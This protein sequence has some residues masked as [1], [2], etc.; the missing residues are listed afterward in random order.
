MGYDPRIGFEFLHPGP[1]YGGSC[2]PKDVAALLHT[3]R[4][5]GLRLRACSRGVV[6]VNRR[7]HERMR[8]EGAR[9]RRRLA[10]RAS[11]V[12]VWGLTF[13]ANT[14]DLRDS[15]ALVIAARLLEE[16]AIV[17][18]YDPAAGEAAAA[19]VPGAR[20]A[21]ADPYEAATGAD[22]LA[23][24]TEWDEFRWLDFERVRR[25]RCARPRDRRRPEPARSGGD[26]PA[27]VRVPGRRPLMAAM[28]SSRAGR[29]RRLAPVRRA[30][31]ARVARSSRSTTSRPA[32]SRTSRTC[33]TTPAFD[34][35]RARRRRRASRSTGRS[36]RCCTSRARPARPSTSRT[37]LETLEVG[38]I[39][40]RRALDLARDQR[41]PVPARVDQ[42]GLRRPAGAPA[43]RDVLRQRQPDRPAV[44]LRRGEALRRGDHDGV[45]PRCTALDTRIVR[46]FNTYGPRLAAGRRAGGVEL[47]RAGD[48]GRAA[49]G[50]RRR[51][52]DAVVLLRRRRGRR[53][54]RAA[55]L[56]P[57][58]A[59]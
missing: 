22:V 20:R 48:A 37:P 47:P 14:D 3:A 18:A 59:R 33:S 9:R 51:Q 40:T 28:R 44:G 8:R 46:I 6:E 58:R 38:S 56:R 55:R 39:G 17:R 27:R 23:L 41:R 5:R 19:L 54:A 57:R 13:K 16:G 29:L 50:L 31:R 12:G 25:R 52:A 26:A 15:P 21:C 53:A 7:Q 32:A 1:G 10:R 2:F 11:T 49:H 30:A 42:R 24:L 34:A 35:G 45:P 43:A 36:T 4:D